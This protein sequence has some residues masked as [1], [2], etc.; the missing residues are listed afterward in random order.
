MMT[1]CVRDLTHVNIGKKCKNVLK[2]FQTITFQLDRLTK[3][4]GVAR[5]RLNQN[6]TLYP[7]LCIHI[8]CYKR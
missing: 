6:F 3:A 7:K 5:R 8:K 2:Y 4:R 1:S